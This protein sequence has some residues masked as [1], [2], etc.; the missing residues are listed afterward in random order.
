MATTGEV[1]LDRCRIAL[2]RRSIPPGSRSDDFDCFPGTQPTASVDKRFDA[3]AEPERTASAGMTAIQP[4]RGRQQARAVE[5]Q[6]A[7]RLGAVHPSQSHA[8]AEPA[9][10]TGAFDQFVAQHR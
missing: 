3:I 10:T 9:S 5:P 4:P 2:G 6:L 7:F 8:A 1:A